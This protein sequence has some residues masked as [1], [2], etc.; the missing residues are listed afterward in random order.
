MTS[1]PISFHE[2][3]CTQLHQ[4]VKIGSAR[5]GNTLANLGKPIAALLPADDSAVEARLWPAISALDLWERSGFP[6]AS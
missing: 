6:P 5:V 3:G 1:I 4:L 2:P